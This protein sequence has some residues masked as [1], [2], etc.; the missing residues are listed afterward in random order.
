MIQVRG[1][2]F[3]YPGEPPVLADWSADIGPGVTQLY[4][5]T[6]S[7]K[8]TLL[9]ILAGSLP[10]DGGQVA[11]AG[12]R[13]DLAPAPY[14][15]Q[16][17]WVDPASTQ[18]DQLSGHACL[19]QLA[20]DAPDPTLRDRLIEGF[21]L[22]P[23]LDKAMYMLSTGSRRKVWLAAALLARRPLTLLDEPAAALDRGSAQHLWQALSAIDPGTGRAVLVASSAAI[24][25]VPLAGCISLPGAG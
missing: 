20:G 19:A 18:F 7:G 23:H 8:S 21:S 13:L 10:P 15:R 2:R 6:G 1:L 9:R 11:V 16:V 14:R 22:A 3:A 12:V 5:D 4:G 17:F 24:S 25:A